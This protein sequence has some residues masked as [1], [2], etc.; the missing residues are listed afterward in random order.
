[1][2]STLSCSWPGEG[3]IAADPLFVDPGSG[4]FQLQAGSPS[5]DAGTAM[6]IWGEDTLIDLHQDEYEG[7]APDMGA[8]ESPYVGEICGLSGLWVGYVNSWVENTV[9]VYEWPGVFE[10]Q[11]PYTPEGN[12]QWRDCWYFTDTNLVAFGWYSPDIGETEPAEWQWGTYVITGNSIVFSGFSG[13]YAFW[14]ATMGFTLE[15]VFDFPD[16]IEYQ[17]TGCRISLT[18]S[19]NDAPFTWFLL[20][21]DTEGLKADVTVLEPPI[22]I[23]VSVDGNYLAIPITYALHQNYPNPFNPTSTIRYDLP[24]ADE[25]SLIV[26]DILGR[27]VIQLVE[28][29]LDPGYHEVQWD[30]RDQ[31]GRM[32]PSGIYMARMVTPGYSKSIKMVLLK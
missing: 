27:E 25:V 5:I 15:P 6:F 7:W 21:T 32:V 20:P 14:N 18:G 13:E 22:Y 29:F 23:P 8:L 11:E 31:S 30:G 12:Y 1:V 19:V 3:N 4:D 24:Q 2:H 28:G 9:T 26:H 10:G 17:H 16:G